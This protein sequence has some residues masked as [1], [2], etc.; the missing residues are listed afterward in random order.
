MFEYNKP[1]EMRLYHLR[2][3]RVHNREYIYDP[4]FQGIK[5]SYRRR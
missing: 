3:Q 4:R 2:Q 1:K 5:R